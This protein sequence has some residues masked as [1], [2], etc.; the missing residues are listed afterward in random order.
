V[1]GDLATLLRRRPAVRYLSA[2]VTAV[3]APGG[4]AVA[5]DLSVYGQACTGVPALAGPAYAIGDVVTLAVADRRAYVLGRLSHPAALTPIDPPAP[6]QVGGAVTFAAVAAGT[7]LDGALRADRTDV[8]QG[9][10]P[11]DGAANLGAWCY[12]GIPAATL[13]DATVTAGRLWLRRTSPLG[14]PPGVTAGLVLHDHPTLTGDAP[15][16]IDTAAYPGVGSAYGTWVD[17]PAG[18]AAELADPA[19]PA[20]GVGV[21][22]AD[23][24]EFAAFAAL[25]ADGATGALRIE[26]HY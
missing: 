12:A 18:W 20:A 15:T 7:Y 4:G 1:L 13:A 8:C 16:V 24:A 21:A 3:A 26:Y 11:A 6:G 25:A 19:A 9:P 17:L 2:T 14:P 10:D 23:P 22:T 5:L